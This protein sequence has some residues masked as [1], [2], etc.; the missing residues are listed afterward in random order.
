MTNMVAVI[1]VPQ[2][3]M[4]VHHEVHILTVGQ[5]YPCMTPVFMVKHMP[6][7]SFS[8]SHGCVWIAN[9]L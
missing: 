4:M 3:S 5:I 8:L 2:L 7:I 9:L 6:G 1:S